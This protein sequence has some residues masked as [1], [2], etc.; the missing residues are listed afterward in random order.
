MDFFGINNSIQIEEIKQS[1]KIIEH[2]E[3]II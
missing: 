3:H 2:L 1:Y